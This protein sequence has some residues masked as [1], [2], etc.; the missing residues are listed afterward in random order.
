M[1]CRAPAFYGSG[2]TQS[3]TTSAILEPREPIT[4]SS[5]WPPKRW[6]LRLAGLFSRT[7]R[8]AG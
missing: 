2:K 3:I 6:Q 1:I 5:G 4:A 8:G 7:V